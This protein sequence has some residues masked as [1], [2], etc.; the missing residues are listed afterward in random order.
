MNAETQPLTCTRRFSIIK[1]SALPKRTSGFNSVLIKPPQGFGGACQADSFF[2][3]FNFYFKKLILK[4]VRKGK[5]LRIAEI[6]LK[7]KVGASVNQQA[8]FQS[9]AIWPAWYLL[10]QDE[11]LG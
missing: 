1:M 9:L 10:V 11:Q 3:S 6:L 7:T 5:E 4:A 2:F 8:L